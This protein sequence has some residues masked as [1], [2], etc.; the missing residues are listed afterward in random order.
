MSILVKI[1]RHNGRNGHY[2]MRTHIHQSEG[3]VPA[4]EKI[5]QKA[6]G[7][8]E[9]LL[10]VIQKEEN[11]FVKFNAMI[12]LL[13]DFFIAEILK[14]TM[15]IKGMQRPLEEAIKHMLVSVESDVIIAKSGRGGF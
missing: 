7:L 3:H 4:E 10:S 8:A 9:R 5:I 6:D 2:S 1:E 11:S 12:Y 14:G 13:G 15:D